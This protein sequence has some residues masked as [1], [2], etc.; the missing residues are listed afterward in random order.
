MADNKVWVNRLVLASL[1]LA[2]STFADRISPPKTG[3]TAR[4]VD[5]AVKTGDSPEAAAAGVRVQEGVRAVPVVPAA[6]G[7]APSV[8][9]APGTSP[10]NGTTPARKRTTGPSAT[11]ANPFA[12]GATKSGAH[13]PASAGKSP[14]TPATGRPAAEAEVAAPL[15]K[16]TTEAFASTARRADMVDAFKSGVTESALKDVLK[17]QLGEELAAKYAADIKGVVDG[18]V[19]KVGSLDAESTRMLAVDLVEAVRNQMELAAS[20]KP[21]LSAAQVSRESMMKKIE[22]AAT[23]LASLGD[24]DPKTKAYLLGNAVTYYA[25]LPMVKAKD[26]QSTFELGMAKF[27]ANLD[28]SGSARNGYL[29][30]LSEYANAFRDSRA[31]GENLANSHLA[32]RR[33]RKELLDSAKLTEKE[34]ASCDGTA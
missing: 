27:V 10:T 23:K 20:A 21:P 12:A 29:K 31:A 16:V 9:I 26:G 28:L 4:P 33:A 8:R 6:Q 17:A 32:G 3:D 11:S 34:I 25:S 22:E 30:L 5:P 15:A 18:F 7:T 1:L 14:A 2:G 19:A 24:I 13:D